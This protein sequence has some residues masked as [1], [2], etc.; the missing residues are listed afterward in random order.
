[1]AYGEGSIKKLGK[2]W[3]EIRLDFPKDSMTGKRNEVRR[4]IRGS[5]QEAVKALNELRRQR[6]GGLRIKGG[7]T[8]LTDL[9]DD[10]SKARE[11]AGTASL[12]TIRSERRALR[13]VER[14]IGNLPVGS[15][16]P[17]TI[18]N[19]Y[20]RIKED[21][22]LSN[23]TIKQIHN[24][25][26]SVFERALDFDYIMRNPCSRVKAPSRNKPN[27]KALTVDEGAKL[28]SCIDKAECQAYTDLALKEQ[29]R[30]KRGDDSVRDFV[31]G[32][33]NLSYIL[34]TRIALATGMRRGEVFGLTWEAF[35]IEASRLYVCQSLLDT[36]KTK[37]PKTEAGYRSVAIDEKTAKCL[38]RWKVFQGFLFR[39]SAVE[40]TPRMPICC[41]NTGG[42]VNLS[43]FEHWWK[44]FRAE[45]EFPDLRFH[46]LRHTQASQLI[47]NG[48]DIKTVQ[49]RLGHANSSMTME[50]THQV[51]QNDIKA[52]NLIGKLFVPKRSTQQEERKK[53]S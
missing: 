38:R 4:R 23:T 16:D 35:D 37:E 14:Y 28:L 32:I 24:S 3:Y 25:L 7:K 5:R 26:K 9:I 52:A 53:A 47:Q 12:R 15:I 18:E 33:V 34:G 46:E 42:Y 49:E 39:D 8:P 43:N 19:V 10:W 44:D 29:R 17:Q 11:L 50:Y 20:S 48:I 13:H 41:S 45:C 22:G 2:D 1:M 30:L 36:G 31:S 40:Q 27:R 51:S 6:D 21:I